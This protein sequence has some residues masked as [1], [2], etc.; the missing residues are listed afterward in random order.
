M[1]ALEG[2]KK[3]GLR[4]FNIFGPEEA[5][6]SDAHFSGVWATLR[7][8][9]VADQFPVRIQLPYW[10]SFP[11]GGPKMD[12]FGCPWVRPTLVLGGGGCR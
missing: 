5:S 6:F 1:G 3:N 2:Q 9:S 8:P 11:Y 7:D 4:K 12:H 10:W